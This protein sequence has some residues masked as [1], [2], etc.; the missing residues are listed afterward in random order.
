MPKTDII[1]FKDCESVEKMTNL[2][3]DFGY[4][5]IFSL[6]DFSDLEKIKFI[7]QN[8]LLIRIN[9][10]TFSKKAFQK[11]IK[12]KLNG[13]LNN[14]IPD[15]KYRV[16][17]DFSDISKDREFIN[18]TRDVFSSKIIAGVAG[19]EQWGKKDS[20]NYKSSG[21]SK[22]L[23]QLAVKNDI[24]VIFSSKSIFEKSGTERSR[25]LG[26][27]KQ[28]I[29]LCTKNKVKMALVSFAQNTQEFSSSE[30]MQPLAEILGMNTKDA[31][32]SIE[33]NIS[34]KVL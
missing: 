23:C 13:T 4:S 17:V 28:N 34:A 15:N 6:V 11:Q 18:K 1:I 30:D 20:L 33:C 19:L 25:I 29:Q 16:I 3:Q 27:I 31:R 26:R 10:E 12:D 5:Q 14:K 22:A 21:M 8:N 9:Y 24:A 32:D 2:S 7:S